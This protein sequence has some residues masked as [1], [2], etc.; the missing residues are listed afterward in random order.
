MTEREKILIGVPGYN[1]IVPEAMQSFLG[2]IFRCGRDLPE[3]DVAVEIVVK[4]EQ[5][6]V[7][8]KHAIPLQ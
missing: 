5:F 3:Y 6:R 7:H 8:L 4:K 2:M 1:G